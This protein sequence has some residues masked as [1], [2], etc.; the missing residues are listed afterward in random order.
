MDSPENELMA[1]KPINSTFDTLKSILIS[2]KTWLRDFY[3]ANF[4]ESAIEEPVTEGTSVKANNQ[5]MH[6]ESRRR[7]ERAVNTVTSQAIS[8]TRGNPKRQKKKII[9]TKAYKPELDRF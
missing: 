6:N 5:D 9:T 1:E 8:S 7:M 3:D 4:G 2:I